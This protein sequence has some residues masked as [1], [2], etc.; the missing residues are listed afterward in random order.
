MTDRSPP[1][2]KLNPY[3]KVETWTI[4]NEQNKV[5]VVDNAALNPEELVEFA[6]SQTRFIDPSNNGSLY[7]GFNAALPPNYISMLISA[8]GRPLA[9]VFGL[10]MRPDAFGFYGLAQTPFEAM[11]PAQAMPHTDTIKQGGFACVHY[12]CDEGFA[13][14]GFY[15]HKQTGYETISPARDSFFRKARTAELAERVGHSNAAILSDCY[16]EIGYSEARF[17][18]LVLYRATILH[19]MLRPCAKPLSSDPKQGRL[20]ANAFINTR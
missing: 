1:E 19:G 8:L 14:T 12:L 6:V 3:A 16:D 15:R 10:R 2:L 13:G 17:N 11:K 7:P 9:E 4:G 20:T 18:R 5:F